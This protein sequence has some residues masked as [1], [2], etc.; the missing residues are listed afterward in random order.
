MLARAASSSDNR[1]GL[2]LDWE[3]DSGGPL[4]HEAFREAFLLHRFSAALPAGPA[5]VRPD[6][7]WTDAGRSGETFRIAY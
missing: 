3:L 4:H 7:A 6:F 2:V 1:H 5:V